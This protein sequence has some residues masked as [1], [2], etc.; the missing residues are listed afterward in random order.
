MEFGYPGSP[1]VADGECEYLNSAEG[2]THE[3]LF[4]LDF[5]SLK[6][7]VFF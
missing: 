4:R 2:I 3:S 5:V 1:F 6:L 7:N